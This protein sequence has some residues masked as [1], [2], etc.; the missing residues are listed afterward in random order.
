MCHQPFSNT[1]IPQSI[2]YKIPRPEPWGKERSANHAFSQAQRAF[3]KHNWRI[4][5]VVPATKIGA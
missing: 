3:R 2:R 5:R 4:A 1:K